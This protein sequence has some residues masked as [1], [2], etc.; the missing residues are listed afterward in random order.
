ML[1]NHLSF[2]IYHLSFIIYH[3]SFIIYHLSFII[4]HLSFIIYHLSFI[5]YHLSFWHKMGF[6]ITRTVPAKQF[7]IKTHKLYV[8]SRNAI[9]INNLNNQI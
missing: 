9:S 1:T 7:G 3:L 5:I 2:I 8:L 4:Y 6:R